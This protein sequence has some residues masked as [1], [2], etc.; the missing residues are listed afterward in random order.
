MR[1]KWF[2]R[3][4]LLLS[5]AGAIAVAGLLSVLP[6]AALNEVSYQWSWIPDRNLRSHF[7]RHREGFL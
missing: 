2:A 5:T 1:T 7:C 6:V 4:R 3:N